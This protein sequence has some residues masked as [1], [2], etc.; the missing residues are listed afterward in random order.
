MAWANVSQQAIQPV[1]QGET[2][3]SE[4]T[5]TSKDVPPPLN[6]TNQAMINVFY[7]AFGEA[8]YWNIIVRVGLA[9]MA[10]HR[11][12]A[13]AGPAVDELDLTIE[14]KDALK[15]ALGG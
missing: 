4:E 9:D 2:L 8:T 10:N 5:S 1:D 13:Y 11:S 6:L 3:S 15:K 7:K 12:D 14:E